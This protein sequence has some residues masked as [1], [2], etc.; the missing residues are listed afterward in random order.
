MRSVLSRAPV[1]RAHDVH[2]GA[3]PYPVRPPRPTQPAQLKAALKARGGK[4]SGLKG[5]LTERLFKA[6]GLAEEEGGGGQ[7]DS[8]EQSEAGSPSVAAPTYAGGSF[9]SMATAVRETEASGA[10]ADAGDVC[11]DFDL[12]LDGMQS[13]IEAAVR[14][15]QQAHAEEEEEVD[16]TGAAAAAAP[17]ASAGAEPEAAAAAAVKPPA[18]RRKSF[19]QSVGAMLKNVGSAIGVDPSP[20]RKPLGERNAKSPSGHLFG[21]PEVV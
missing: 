10:A 21:A 15:E 16:E 20:V 1:A 6:C 5:V 9:G 8:P 14:R 2:D 17:E 18:T 7:P 19:K 11:L 13:S 4:V 3:I 12:D